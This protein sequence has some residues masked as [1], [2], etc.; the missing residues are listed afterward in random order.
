MIVDRG[1]PSRQTVVVETAARLHFGVLDL[2]GSLGRWF[3]GIGAAAPGP[4]LR[5]LARPAHELCVD[6]EDATRALEFAQ[7]FVRHYR[8]DAAVH[9]HVERALPPH[10]GLGSGT[11]LALAVGRAIAE[12]SG[13]T[14]T[15]VE[16]A[17]AVGRTK[18]SAVGTWTFAGGGLVVE[19]GRRREDDGVSPLLA[20]IPLP[21]SWRCVVAVPETVCG[22]SGD[23]EADA[24]AR[25]P[26][27]DDRDVERVAHLVLMGLLPA[28][29][30][31]DINAFG[32]ALTAIQ[33]I[34]GRWFAPIQGGTF[35]SSVSADLVRRMMGWG[36]VGVGQSSWGPTV[37]G[38]VEGESAASQLAQRVQAAMS[39]CGSV[40]EGGF[41]TEGAWVSRTLDA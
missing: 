18:R 9:V 40:Y 6:G 1:T 31:G 23:A 5:V 32:S 2:R 8:L 28:A 38:L 13:I 14:P 22:I 41:R 19:G 27:I 7:R 10:K 15:A 39:A 21:T 37:Y 36:A 17:T 3:G 29:A 30:E 20:R 25:I 11:Q 33:T 16:L 12:V 24:F 34:T 4:I 35:A 26:L